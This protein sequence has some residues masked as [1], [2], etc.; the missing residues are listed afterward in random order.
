LTV[1]G[2]MPSW[3]AISFG[4]GVLT[5]VNTLVSQR[6]GAGRKDEIARGVDVRTLV[7]KKYK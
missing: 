4:F 5:L 6:V 7:T 2:E 3:V 1:S